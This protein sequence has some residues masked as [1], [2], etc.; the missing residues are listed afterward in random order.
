MEF[1]DHRGVE[2]RTIFF[3]TIPFEYLGD[4]ASLWKARGVDGFMLAGIMSNW[5]SDIWNVG[6]E[7]VVGEENLLFKRLKRMN[8][9]CKLAGLDC[10]FVKVAFY[11]HLPDWFDDAGWDQLVDN[12]RQASIFARDAGFR[13]I[14]IDIEYIAEIYDLSWPSY[15][16][17]GYRFEELREVVESRGKQMIEAMLVEFPSMEL[18]HL[19]QSPEV[20]GRLASDIFTGM[21]LGMAEN[22]APGGIHILTEGTYQR[23]D[24]DWLIRYRQDL[25]QLIEGI[26]PQE[27][28]QYWRESC[29]ISFG[30]WPLGYYRDLYDGD[31]NFLGYGGKREKFGDEVVGST[32]DKSENYSV[33]EFRR[34][35]AVSRMV[36]DRYIWIYCHGSTFWKL[37][38]EEMER[39][40][41]SR[42]DSLPTVGDLNDYL[43]VLLRRQVLADPAIVDVASRIRKRSWVDFLEG[44]GSPRE[45]YLLGPF[46]NEENAGFDRKF[47]PEECIDENDT[48]EGKT[49]PV[50]WR[51]IK[52][53]SSGHVDLSHIYRPPDYSLAYALCYMKSEGTAKGKIL[54][55]SDDGVKVWLG[56]RLVHELDVVRGAEPD[57][58]VV[59]IDIDAGKIPILL[60]VCNHKGS[61]GFYFRIVGEDGRAIPGVEFSTTRT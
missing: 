50:G 53:S 43:E 57:D 51:K 12:F 30:L 1:E 44:A 33:E 31:G 17:E 60:K 15:H 46:S 58:D 61:W 54:I 32:A 2:P 26:I 20:Y 36:C 25:D 45:W 22:T 29:S 40:R 28:I 18:L 8:K 34:Q 16:V 27:Y 10:N 47:P 49:G 42:S 7:R 55:G 41:G 59:P 9:D 6:E 21:F 52:V 11:S 13:G 23:T 38:G 3:A 39:Y 35:F 24:P 4:T 19:P 48:Y 14:A 56:D 37:D 5:D